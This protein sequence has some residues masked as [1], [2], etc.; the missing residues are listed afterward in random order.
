MKNLIIIILTL[1]VLAPPMQAHSD[2]VVYDNVENHSDI[3]EL[4]EDIHH[5]N[6]SSEEKDRDHHH[7]CTVISLSLEFL[8]VTYNFDLLSF[9]ES[10]KEINFYQN[11]YCNSYLKAIFQPPKA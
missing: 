10:K 4:H 2:V 5:E 3:D 1:L 7:H 6:D 9:V 11:K 8:Q